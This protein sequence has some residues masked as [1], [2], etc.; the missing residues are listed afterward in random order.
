MNL[1]NYPSVKEELAGHILS[2]IED[3]IIDNTNI[4]DW[5]FHC[6]NEDY[7]IIGYY[8]ASEWF[9]RHKIDAFNAIG[10]CLEYEK[11]VF[12]EVSTKY[13]NAETTV[14]MFVYILGEELLSEVAAPSIKKLKKAMNNIIG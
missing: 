13:D 10:T 9:K 3:G 5:H 14:N 7:Y 11:D 12:G 2:R 1:N 8:Q 6:F 4:D